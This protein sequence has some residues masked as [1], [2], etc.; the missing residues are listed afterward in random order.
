M[1]CLVIF[2]FL[3]LGTEDDYNLSRYDHMSFIEIVVLLFI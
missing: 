1:I 3:D 2:G